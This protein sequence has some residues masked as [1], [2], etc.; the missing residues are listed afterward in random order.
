MYGVFYG[1]NLH[2][3]A[4][5]VATA[6]W[7][8]LLVC[9]I[10]VVLFV[11]C[12]SFVIRLLFGK[13]DV[14]IRKR[15]AFLFSGVGFFFSCVTP[16]ASGGQPVQL[17]YM[18]RSGLSTSESTNVLVWVTVLYKLVL[19]VI[20]VFLFLF[21]MDYVNTFM[22]DC[23]WI[24][25]LGLSLNIAFVGLLILL[26][27]RNDW[28]EQVGIHGICL[29]EKLRI[30]RK[31]EHM[32]EKWKHFAEGYAA[33]FSVMKGQT[34]IIVVAFLVTFLQRIML[35]A[36]T[37]FVYIAFGL[38]GESFWHIVLLQAMIAIAVDM[39]PLPGGS[40]ISE[41]LF[42]NMFLP[43]FGSTLILPGMVLSRGIAY[44]VQLLL[45]GI[46][47]MIAYFYFEQSGNILKRKRHEKG[48]EK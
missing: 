4:K 41:H 33:A 20:G 29:L 23:S 8:W 15:E 5:N 36:I 24:F 35:F 34:G 12:E 44:Y 6:D 7:K 32:I 19:V 17:I 26:W 28:L 47:T 48:N 16:S 25:Y 21:R 38:V 42:E 2:E 13:L 1:E 9:I 37:G 27:C 11:Y 46:I 14:F 40:G 22:D 10:L 45:C 18:K 3:L 43:I 30:V 31:K 39:L